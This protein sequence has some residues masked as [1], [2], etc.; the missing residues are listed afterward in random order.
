MTAEAVV[1]KLP[2]PNCARASRWCA[3]GP[4]ST[5]AALAAAAPPTRERKAGLCTACRS[6]IKDIFDTAD[7]PT[8]YGS[9]IYTRHRP[10]GRRRLRWRCRARAGALVIGK[11]V[12]TEFANL[13]PGPTAQ[14]A[15]PG[16]HAGRLV[17]RFGRGGRRRHGAAGDRHADRRFDHPAR[18]VLRRRRIQAELRP[19]SAGRHAPQHRA[20]RHGRRR[21]RAR[22]ADIALFRAALM[23]MPVEPPAMPERPP[24]LALCRT[25][26]G[27]SAQPEG[28]AMLEATAARLTAAGAE[29][30]DSELPGVRRHLRRAAPAQRVRG[31][32]QSSAPQRL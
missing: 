32:A 16:A 25:R 26:T 28:K 30:I 4:I 31:A 22:L 17:E 21:W 23:A 24:R 10:A 27:T 20:P 3:P 13:H 15:Q 11:T 2:R 6:A 8:G 12:T 14:S 7:M 5:G 18:R 9:P 19:V 29:I 1:A